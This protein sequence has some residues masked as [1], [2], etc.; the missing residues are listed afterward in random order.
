M[1]NRLG[2]GM[3]N[4]IGVLSWSLEACGWHEMGFAVR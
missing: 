3:I 2:K 4:T 1:G